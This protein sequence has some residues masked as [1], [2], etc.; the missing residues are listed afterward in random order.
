MQQR[1]MTL[2]NRQI[3][4]GKNDFYQNSSWRSNTVTHGPWWSNAV[5][6]ISR[7]AYS[8]P[9]WGWRDKAWQGWLA[10]EID[11]YFGL[12]NISV[13][14]R[15]A[16]YIGLGRCWENAVIFLTHVDNVHKKAQWTNQDSYLAATLTGAFS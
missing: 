13:S 16:D 4:E 15:L 6:C 10:L 2:Q 1:L 11:R 14:A 7:R 3:I 8:I 12:T 5:A 9:E